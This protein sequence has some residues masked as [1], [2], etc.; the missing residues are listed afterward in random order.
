[1]LV[2]ILLRTLIQGS[3]NTLAFNFMRV[4]E[5]EYETTLSDVVITACL[6]RQQP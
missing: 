2:V 4:T 5:N 6:W 3:V 1:M